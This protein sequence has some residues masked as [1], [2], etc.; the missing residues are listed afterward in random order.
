MVATCDKNNKPI[1]DLQTALF[2]ATGC[3]A[4]GGAYLCSSF[5]P[6][7]VNDTLSYGFAIQ[8]TGNN[9]VGDNPNCCKCYEVNWTS[10]PASEKNKRMIVQI[11]TPGGTGGD[12]K[13]GDL[14]I[15]SPGGGLGP[16]DTGCARQ[17]GNTFDW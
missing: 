10:G 3:Q 14:I 12:V 8:V 16:F 1:A 6:I 11:V 5:A 7:P 2:T 9:N 15:L 17:Y 13:V 4:G